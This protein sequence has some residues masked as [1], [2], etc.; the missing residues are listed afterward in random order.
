MFLGEEDSCA[1]FV[2][3]F[4]RFCGGLVG[5]EAV[6]VVDGRE[7]VVYLVVGK[8]FFVFYSLG[9]TFSTTRLVLFGS[10]LESTR[11]VVIV[12]LGVKC[13]YYFYFVWRNGFLVTMY[14]VI[15][16]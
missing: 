10:L 6:R 13:C 4:V 12:V 8:D 14:K 5:C 2:F 15:W 1:L 9:F 3:L 16:C 7:F 11:F